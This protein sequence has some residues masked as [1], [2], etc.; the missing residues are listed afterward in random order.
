[1]TRVV[2]QGYVRRLVNTRVAHVDLTQAAQWQQIA[3]A[4]SDAANARLILLTGYFQFSELVDAVSIHRDPAI[5]AIVS[6]AW[7]CWVEKARESLDFGT[8]CLL[9]V[10]AGDYKRY[11]F[12]VCSPAYF[13]AALEKL[14]TRG[15]NG[16]IFVVTD[17]PVSASDC[18]EGIPHCVLP[19]NDPLQ[20]LSLV[21]K[22]RYKVISNSTLSLWGALFGESRA[23]VFPAHWPANSREFLRIGSAAGWILVR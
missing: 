5:R 4:L 16:R 15:F 10:R 2:G 7:P 22:F 17:D 8:D 14:R 9:H 23:C 12:P 11:G 21:A 13:A 3:S 6:R 19:V 18:L 1:M 20:V